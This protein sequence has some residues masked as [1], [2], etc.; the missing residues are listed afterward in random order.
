MH[1]RQQAAMRG[2]T[3]YDSN[4]CKKCGTTKRRT[5]N[6]SCIKCSN[7]LSRVLSNRRRQ[8]IKSLLAGSEGGD[9]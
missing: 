4:P 9:Q 6:A 7:E 5:I 1:P 2:E 8:E 3:T